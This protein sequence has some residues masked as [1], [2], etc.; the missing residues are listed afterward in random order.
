MNVFRI[1]RGGYQIRE[2]Q[3]SFLTQMWSLREGYLS[4]I[5][6]QH[7]DRY[8]QSP[9]RGIGDR[10]R[11]ISPLRSAKDWKGST[12]ERVERVENFDVRAFCAQGIVGVGA[13][14]RTYTA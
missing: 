9:P 5:R 4:A 3:K 10:H 6:R 13:F 1:E 2:R 7:P 8:L 12:V 11:P 14:I